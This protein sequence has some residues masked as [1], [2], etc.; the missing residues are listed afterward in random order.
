MQSTLLPQLRGH[1]L[2]AHMLCSHSMHCPH[3]NMQV[4]LSD[5]AK[6]V[7]RRR[8]HAPVSPGPD[9]S[10]GAGG[11]DA[12]QSPWRVSAGRAKE[13]AHLGL[14]PVAGRWAFG[15]PVKVH[16]GLYLVYCN[17]CPRSTGPAGRREQ[18]AGGSF[19]LCLTHFS[20]IFST[21]PA[22]RR[23]QRAGG[24]AGGGRAR[25]RCA[26]CGLGLPAVS[27]AGAEGGGGW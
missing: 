12:A 16:A 5:E 14:L 18:P 1:Y 7:A 2:E 25:P 23:E 26:R 3:N 22:G 21:G 24:A 17:W 13:C 8:G 19:N 20:I 11:G 6:R 10:P 15:G 9:E 4:L 27:C